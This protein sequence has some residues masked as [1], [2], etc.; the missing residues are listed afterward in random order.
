MIVILLAYS[1]VIGYGLT[2]VAYSARQWL[3]HSNQFLRITSL[4]GALVGNGKRL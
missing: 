1:F 2:A 3:L 4:Y